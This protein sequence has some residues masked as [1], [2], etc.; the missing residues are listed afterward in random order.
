MRRIK[1]TTLW[2]AF[3]AFVFFTILISSVIMFGV[4]YIMIKGYLSEASLRQHA[5]P[6]L[7]I[8]VLFCSSIL[9]ATAINLFLG[10][11]VLNPISILSKAM[12]AVAKGDFNVQLKY[13][14][15]VDE[16]DEM[17]SNFN[18][19]VKELGAIE[20]LRNDFVVSVSH[21]FRT[22]L[23]VIEGYATILQSP[24]LNADERN[25]YAQNII[26]ST[27]QLAKLSSNILLIS[28]LENKELVSENMEFQLD[29]Q[30]RQSILL[31]QPIWETK[32]IEFNI[33]LDHARYYGNE[34]LLTHVWSN[35]IG[36]AIKFTP[37]N[38]EITISL[39]KTPNSFV[40]TIR[41]TG[42]GISLDDQRHIFDKFYQADRSRY[43]DGNGL[44][45]SLVKRIIN[46]FHGKIALE[47]FPGLGTNFTIELPNN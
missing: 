21:E 41:D 13:G 22:P 5:T 36:N 27:K 30:L 28:N 26:E 14:E 42:I 39:K 16:L 35:L 29:E 23:S 25:E 18:T 40:V 43:T 20:T 4:T 8:S 31:L 12:M 6:A 33:E 9:T 19:M 46:L 37:K 38:G 11:K 2:A 3:A 10:R 17:T 24:T 7:P 32:K 1:I 44:G 15:R 45:L 34:E 47:S